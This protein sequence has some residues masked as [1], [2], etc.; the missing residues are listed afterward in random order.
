MTAARR[1]IQLEEIRIIIQNHEPSLEELDW[2]TWLL[3]DPLNQKL[4]DLDFEYAM[5]MF[6]RD[7]LLAKRRKGGGGKTRS[8]NYVLSFSG[9]TSAESTSDYVTTTFNPDDYA[10]NEGF[11]VSYWV[12]PDFLGNTMFALGRKPSNSQRFQF[13]I[14]TDINFF[15]GAGRLRTR[16]TPH[17]MKVGT[18]YHWAVTY[19]GDSSDRTIKIYRDATLLQETTARWGGTGATGGELRYI[20]VDIVLM[21][22]LGEMNIRLDGLLVLMK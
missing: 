18:W 7:N 16:N 3:S 4:A 11:T 22:V 6:K 21:T 17:G 15:V 8:I 14:N 13:G 12:R 5:E 10:L 19:A 9:N 20:L 1:I 2:T